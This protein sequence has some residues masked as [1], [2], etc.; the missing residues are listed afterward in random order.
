VPRPLLTVTLNA[1]VDKTY[2]VPGFA[3]NHVHRPQEMRVTAGGKGVNVARVYQTLGGSATATGF[4]A[5]A[6]G[7]F[8]EGRLAA[9]NIGNGFVRVPSESRV[10]I[11]VM[12][13]V[14]QTQ[15][16]INETG[17]IVSP[18]DCDALMV[19]LRE[20]LPDCCA[21][22]ISGSVP[23]GTPPGIYRD[24]I[25]LAQEEYGVRA[26]LDASG[27]ALA[28]GI[29]ARPF[30]VKP[31]LHELSALG[32]SSKTASQATL[33]V[34]Q[35]YG[36]SLAL[37][38]AGAR[39]AALASEDGVWEATPPTITVQSAVGFGDSL[40]AGFMWALE[41][42]RTRTEALQIGVAAGAANA[43]TYGAGY[44][45]RAQVMAL[46]AQTA[47]HPVE[48]SKEQR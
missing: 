26:V 42:G 46:A 2:L 28:E 43:T 32:I 17:P 27:D 41:Q 19:R 6:N 20:L 25:T 10:C 9:E 37:V 38:T 47:V 11:A 18:A 34:R 23:P 45:D 35:R 22:V 15:T 44:L 24:I 39:G 8:I 16:E 36:V 40:A 33:E 14:A 31:N 3:L 1:A 29:Q 5:G 30:L 12:D 4:I 13:P 7:A 48:Y 21:V